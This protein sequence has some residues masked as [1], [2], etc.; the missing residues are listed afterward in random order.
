VSWNYRVLRTTDPGGPH[1]F[2]IREVFYDTAGRVTAWSAAATWPQSE[3]FAGLTH[4][5]A[6]YQ[7]AFQQPVL[8]ETDG[9]L[10]DLGPMGTSRPRQVW[11]TPAPE[12]RARGPRRRA[13]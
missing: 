1:V 9:R 10:E 6:A 11:P 8:A 4:E 13:R 3:T 7:A 5:V 2:A 12:R